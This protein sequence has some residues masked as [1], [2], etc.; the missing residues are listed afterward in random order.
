MGASEGEEGSEADSVFRAQSLLLKSAPVQGKTFSTCKVGDSSESS[1][2]PA[3]FHP[4]IKQVPDQHPSRFAAIVQCFYL[5]I[6]C[7]FVFFKRP[8]SD[9]FSGTKQSFL[10]VFL[11]RLEWS[12]IIPVDKKVNF[13]RLLKKRMVNVSVFSSLFAVNFTNCRYVWSHTPVQGKQFFRVVF[14]G[15]RRVAT[16][17]FKS[18]PGKGSVRPKE[19][20]VTGFKGDWTRTGSLRWGGDRN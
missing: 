16:D 12:E 5:F 10:E 17:C 1:S 20:S 13:S 3:A 15:A 7:A 4:T 11:T 2:A 18:M 19:F 6:M 9:Y 8:S 14:L